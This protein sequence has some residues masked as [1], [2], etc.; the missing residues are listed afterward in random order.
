MQRSSRDIGKLIF[1]FNSERFYFRIESPLLKN[2]GSERLAFRLSF[3]K[4]VNMEIILPV[5]K[6]QRR[7]ILEDSGVRWVFDDFLDVSIPFE[8]LKSAA[9]AEAI[10]FHAGIL[11]K[12]IEI[13]RLPEDSGIILPFPSARFDEENWL[14]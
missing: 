14:V 1:G 10:E 11:E 13:E 7:N 2:P 12:G 3:T 8:R 4:P 5:N 9:D 6:E